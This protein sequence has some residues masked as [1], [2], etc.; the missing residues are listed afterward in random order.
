M[1]CLWNSPKYFSF[2]FA[3]PNGVPGP[4]AHLFIRFQKRI[5]GSHHGVRSD[6]STRPPI[7]IS[8]ESEVPTASSS[9]NLQEVAFC[10]Q[11]EDIESCCLQFQHFDLHFRSDVYHNILE[12]QKTRPRSPCH[13]DLTVPS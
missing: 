10:Q 1:K 11:V 6:F 5:R 12:F 7:S 9:K 3:T 13:L 4:V 8:P 2:L